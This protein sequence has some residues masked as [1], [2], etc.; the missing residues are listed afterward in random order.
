M[1]NADFKYLKNQRVYHFF[2][3]LKSKRI[4]QENKGN[5]NNL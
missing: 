2:L 1:K 4:N 5:S 3:A